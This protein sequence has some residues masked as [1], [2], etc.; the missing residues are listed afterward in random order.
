MEWVTRSNPIVKVSNCRKSN[1]MCK[2]KLEVFTCRHSQGHKNPYN[3]SVK[4]DYVYLIVN[5]VT[6]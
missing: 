5:G 3:H 4:Y 6:E 1:T 2:L